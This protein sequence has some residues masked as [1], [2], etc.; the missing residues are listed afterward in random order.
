M[1]KCTQVN[2]PQVDNSNLPCEEYIND[3]C[4]IVGEAIPYIGSTINDS[5]EDV[6]KLMV[7]KMKQQQQQLINLR[8]VVNNLTP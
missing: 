5:L 3:E 6:I 2:I 4:I 1:K 7:L 8:N